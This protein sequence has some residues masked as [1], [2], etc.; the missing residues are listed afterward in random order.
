MFL[1]TSKCDLVEAFCFLILT[2]WKKN[3]QNS[4]II[5]GAIGATS[6]WH[7]ATG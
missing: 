7:L 5:G 2:F 6:R 1:V 4:F 3:K